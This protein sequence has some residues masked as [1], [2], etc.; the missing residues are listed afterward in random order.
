MPYGQIL[1]MMLAL[2][3]IESAPESVPAGLGGPLV[4]FLFT[5]KTVGWFLFC[6]WNYRRASRAR[7]ALRPEALE[8]LALIPL[9]VDYYFLK[10]NGF[11]MPLAVQVHLPSLGEVIGLL[12]FIFYLLISWVC[13]EGLSRPATMSRWSWVYHRLTL[14]LPILLPYL[15]IT[16]AADIFSQL[17]V[18][19]I[20]SAFSGPYAP[21]YLLLLLLAFFFVMLPG[22]VKRLWRCIP[23]PQSPLRK[24]IEEGLKRQGIT[25]SDILVW[26]AGEAMACTAAVIGILP[27]FRYVLLTPCLINHLSS[28]EIEAV[29]AHE[30]EHVRRKHLLWYLAFLIAYS[31]II[32]RL[33]D[34]VMSLL[35]SQ[36]VVLKYLLELEKLPGS[37]SALLAA[38]PLGILTLFFF[39]YVL[40]Y[41]MR[42]FERQADSAVFKVQGHPFALISALRKVAIL[43]GIDPARPNWHHY[44]IK[45][46]I[47]FL[48]EAYRN[49]QLLV[50]HDKRLLAAKTL[51]ISISLVCVLLPS[52]LPT[53]SWQKKAKGNVAVLLYN[54]FIKQ[55]KKDPMW[56]TQI[57]SLLF[58]NGMYEQAESALKEAMKLDPDN[59]DILNNLAWLYVKAKDDRFYHPRQALLLAME[60]A[61]L[62]PESYILDTLAES[63]F[64]NGYY[65]RAVET[66]RLALKKA[67]QNREYY[68]KQLDRFLKAMKE[69]AK[70]SS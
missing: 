36:P 68:K 53:A 9:V 55:K 33:S 50:L 29:I 59:P 27:G 61:R 38:I 30:A 51:F 17:P 8:W 48:E 21:F 16:V 69:A 67:R 18:K 70:S 43:S 35:L 37:V 25:F 12:L 4:L 39:R 57:S 46:R 3:L 40:G 54:E 23:L 14:L 5:L 45:E 20:S 64:A 24:Q 65:K 11:F 42:N 44:S 26:P 66:E 56:L 28:E 62:K 10:I 22:L 31:L 52:L 34:P 60:A 7:A 41:F 47:R 63:F 32:Y 6:C 15:A 2:I 13:Q 1:E 58:D 19:W 49:R